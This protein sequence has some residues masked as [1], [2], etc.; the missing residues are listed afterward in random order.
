MVT[1]FN[2]TNLT[3]PKNTRPRQEVSRL[4]TAAVI[5]TQFR[6]M[7][8][9]NPAKAIN[10]GY[11]GEGFQLPR[12]QQ[13]KLATIQ[14]ENLSEFASQLNTTDPNWGTYLATD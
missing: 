5:S 2:E 12:E 14:A 10:S 3:G 11:G 4:L 8:L 6:K 13:K 9:A 1:K 7:L